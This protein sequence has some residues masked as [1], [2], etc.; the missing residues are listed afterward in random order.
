MRGVLLDGAG[1]GKVLLR[2]G[3][4]EVPL[5]G[6][7]DPI[8][9]VLSDPSLGEAALDHDAP[10]PLPR[11]PPSECPKNVLDRLPFP[12]G[13]GPVRQLGTRLEFQVPSSRLDLHLD[14]D[15]RLQEV[16]G[17]EQGEVGVHVVFEIG[18]LRKGQ[19]FRLVGIRV[20]E[21]ALVQR[22][23]REPPDAVPVLH[24]ASEHV[25][26]YVGMEQVQHVRALEPAQTSQVRGFIGGARN[27]LAVPSERVPVHKPVPERQYTGVLLGEHERD[28]PYIGVRCPLQGDRPR[29]IGKPA[30]RENDEVIQVRRAVGVL[31][32][33][34]AGAEQRGELA[35]GKG[36]LQVRDFHVIAS[37]RYSPCSGAAPSAPLPPPSAS[38][39]SP[40]S[41]T[42]PTGS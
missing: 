38:P 34:D 25:D 24:L 3:V 20:L 42:S 16:P 29:S 22:H 19:L 17:Q 37:R 1:E 28:Q 26:R 5:E 33:I 30:L 15:E 10:R 2:P 39:A 9:L 21:R 8:R 13:D 40:A 35:C 18:A 6:F 41:R 11:C 23:L 4:R 7:P 32:Q 27:T 31:G 36:R 14:L 12:E